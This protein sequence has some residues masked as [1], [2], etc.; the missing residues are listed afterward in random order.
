[1]I[2]HVV[3]VVESGP[4][5][6]IAILE[7]HDTERSIEVDATLLDQEM[8]ECQAQDCQTFRTYLVKVHRRHSSRRDEDLLLCVED[9]QR[10]RAGEPL[11]IVVESNR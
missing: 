2:I 1:M 4:E 9:L 5:G 10:H 8:V 7:P 3:D 6:L 11:R